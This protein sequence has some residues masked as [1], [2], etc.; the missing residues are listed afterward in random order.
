MSELGLPAV[1][2]SGRRQGGHGFQEYCDPGLPLPLLPRS[3]EVNSSRE[4]MPSHEALPQ[5]GAEK[6]L[7]K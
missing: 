2:T 7:A 3:G 4:H 1:G 6:H 5:A